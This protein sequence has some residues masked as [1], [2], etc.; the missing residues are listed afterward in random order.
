MPAPKK[1]PNTA[2]TENVSVRLDP[3]L[4]YLAGLAAREQGRTLSNFVEWAVRR[5]LAEAVMVAAEEPTPGY[6]PAPPQPLWMES[7][8]EP[9]ET[10]RFFS[11]GTLRPDLLE[12][13]SEQRRWNMFLAFAETTKNELTIKAFRAFMETEPYRSQRRT[14]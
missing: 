1:A 14:R 13:V 7:L 6:W 8:W 12:P 3:K 4:H 2:K 10:E 11:L 5:T 9:D